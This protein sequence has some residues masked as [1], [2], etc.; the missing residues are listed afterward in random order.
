MASI[1]LDDPMLLQGVPRQRP[2]K[3]MEHLEG[4]WVGEGVGEFPPHVPRFQ[5]VQELIIEKAVP[6]STKE[7]N[8]SFRSVIYDKESRQGLK[9]EWGYLRF[10][11]VAIDHGKLEITCTDPSGQCEIDEGTYTEDSFDVWTRYG[12][13]T[14]TET[15]ARPAITE[16]RRKCE[17]RPQNS[18]IS[19]EY[20]VEMATE[21]SQMQKYML[22]RLRKEG[23]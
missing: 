12:G 7:L 3:L 20:E 16:V 9:S 17:I 14:R 23:T 2:I 5:Y 11:P 22:S 13:L 6:H 10:H 4:V 1:F 8:W 18:P 15:A 21:R 19:M